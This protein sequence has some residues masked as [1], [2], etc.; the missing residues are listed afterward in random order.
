MRIGV[1]GT[2]MVG[3]AL[4]T[5]LV[6]LGHEVVMGS[7]TPGN[8]TA[9]SWAARVGEGGA[10]GTFEAA[11]R[12]G[13]IVV[14]A[15]SGAHSL[16]ALRAAGPENLAGKVL[17]DVANPLA[18]GA[19]LPR[20]DPVNDD[21]LGERIQRE[22]PAARVVKT[23]N[24]VN[25]EVM[26]DPARVPGRHDV[27]LAGEDAAAKEVV[28]ELLRAFG[29]PDDSIRDMGGIVAARGLEMYLIFWIVQRLVL[30]SHDFNIRI[31]H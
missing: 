16:D 1:L 31:V 4:A 30:G 3:E 14:N 24:T 22:H 25:C 23:L 8:E 18:A 7:R 27:F 19:P 17:V 2:G 9:A 5:R 15:T 13:E 20:L 10:A 26:V 6:G 29:W 28:R 21:S 12:H 11:A